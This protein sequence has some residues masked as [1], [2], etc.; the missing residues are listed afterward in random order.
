[1]NLFK[2]F[3]TALLFVGLFTVGLAEQRVVMVEFESNKPPSMGPVNALLRQG[4]RVVQLATARATITDTFL[5][6]AH[7]VF[8]LESPPQPIALDEGSTDD[9][10]YVR[11]LTPA[12]IAREKAK[13]KE[14]SN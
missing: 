3:W 2:S 1:M 10:F 5:W 6:T 4:W 12:E 7:T 8:V 11:K 14:G 13:I 9:L